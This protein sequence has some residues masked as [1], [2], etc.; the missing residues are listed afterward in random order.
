MTHR[1]LTRRDALRL[2]IAAGAAAA[3]S[4][5][6][7]ALADTESDL[8][9]AQSQLDKVQAQLDQIAADYE[10]LSE[11]NSRTK[12]EIEGVQDQI[13]NTQGDIDKKQDELDEKKEQLSKRVSSA[14][15][16]GA[17]GFLSVLFSSTS[18]EELSSNI[19]YLDKISENDK[20]MI[21]DVKSIKA[22]LETKKEELES[23]KGDLEALNATQVQQLSD[24]QAKQDEAT[25]TLNGLSQ[26]VKDL[27]AQRDAELEAMAKERAAQEAAAAAAAASSSSRSNPNTNSNPGGGSPNVTGDLPSGGSTTGSQQR[28]INACYS[29]PSPGAGLCAMWVSRVFFNAGYGYA[30]GNANDMYNAWCYSSD[31]SALQPGMIVAVSTHSHTSAGRIYGHIGIYIGGGM[32]ME[33]IG[34]I[35]TQSVNSWISYYGTTVTPRW[36]WLMGIQLA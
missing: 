34:S 10:A 5:A 25:R 15:K 19:Y 32:I 30:S 31:R 9:A 4:P 7:H 13:D 28:V 6:K 20:Q 35:N 12:D 21:E 24:M 16:S 26:Q 14:Y 8:A 36:G 1:N 22:E 23:Q 33:N 3:M 2:F 29:T 11:E 17:D 27:M 18:F